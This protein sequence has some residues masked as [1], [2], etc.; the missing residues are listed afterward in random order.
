M[1]DYIKKF[2]YSGYVLV[3]NLINNKNLLNDLKQQS[4]NSINK[5]KAGEWKYFRI[6]NDYPNFISNGPNIFGIEYPFNSKLNIYILPLF[7]QIK[8]KEILLK[9][10]GWNNYETV[11][12][13]LHYNPNFLNYSNHWHRDFGNYPSL[14]SIQG[15]FYLENEKGFRIVPKHKNNLLKNY[16]ISTT[17]HISHEK[18]FARL[19][20]D[21][22]EEIDAE[23]GDVLFFYS[24][25]L[26]Q[27]NCRGKRLHY[28]IRF[29]K[30]N[31]EKDSDDLNLSD[32][33]SLN[34]QL[35]NEINEYFLDRNSIKKD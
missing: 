31:I 33:M 22:F 35:K 15:V 14:D 20:K 16:N 25:L 2:N 8:F 10:S 23:E 17:D 21:M 19:K 1:N 4:Y 11:L 27:A 24:T 34:Y 13:R 6:Y 9:I 32:E 26:H 29:N 30:K 28:H 5:A 7:F 3:K 18:E 12:A